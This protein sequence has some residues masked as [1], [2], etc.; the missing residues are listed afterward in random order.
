MSSMRQLA[1]GWPVLIVIAAWVVLGP[2]GMA[3]DSCAAMMM[4]CDGGPCGVVAAVTFSAPVL[5]PPIT[6]ATTEPTTPEALPVVSVRALD[7]PPK[8]LPLSV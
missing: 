3:F 8:S 2:I 4:L 6:I 1:R 7:P 5:A